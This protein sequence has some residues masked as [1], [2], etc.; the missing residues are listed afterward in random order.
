MDT[1]RRIRYAESRHLFY[2]E[3]KILLMIPLSIAL[4]CAAYLAPENTLAAFRK[5]MEI[6]ADGGE[7][8]VQ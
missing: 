3:R 1:A 4:R 7:I 6:G 5:A 8:D 2:T